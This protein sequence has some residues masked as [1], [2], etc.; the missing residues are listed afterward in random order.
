MVHE[1]AAGR[2][3]AGDDVDDAV[4]QA[5]LG[6]DFREAQRGEAGGLGGLEDDGVAA[7]EGRGDFPRGHEEGEVP[8]DDLPGD[9]E[10]ARRLAGEGILQL[11]G[12][13]G[14]VEEVRG[15]QRQVEV[16]GFLDGLAAVEGFED[17]ELAGFLLDDA[18]D[19]VEVFAA[20]AGGELG[21]D[22]VVG[23]T[24]GLHGAV[25]VHVV[26]EG[27]LRELLLGGG[28]EGG[29]VFARVR[30]DELAPDEELVTRRDGDVFE[31]LRCGRVVPLRAEVEE[32]VLRGDGLGRAGNNG[33]GTLAPLGQLRHAARGE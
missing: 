15:N 16:A 22:A 9:A 19:A 12:P 11:V 17:G 20:L 21:P 31:V 27:D 29:E 7:R 23:G 33:G 14:V 8:R 10:R 25:H 6:E 5:G 2:A 3:R 28:V 13:A 26:G 24:G 1:R 4:G 32:A 30:R 18:R